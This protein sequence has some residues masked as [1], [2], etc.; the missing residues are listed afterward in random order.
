MN[1]K[2]YLDHLRTAAVL[3]LFPY[4]TFMIYN[5]WG[6]N[7]YI[8]GKDL[9]APSL[10]NQLNWLWMMPLILLSSITMTYLTYEAARRA[11]PLRW[12]FGL[13]K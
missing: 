11:A 5:N 13:K 3:M 8:H 7:W 4:H 9:L 6:E 12:M 1:R 10:I 2:H